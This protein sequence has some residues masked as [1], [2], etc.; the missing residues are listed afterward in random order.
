MAD[1]LSI[2]ASL[3]GVATAAVQSTR[4]LKEAAGRYKTRDATLRRLL[5]E[6]GDVE[7]ILTALEQLLQA[8]TSQPALDVDMSMA[9]L[10]QGPIERCSE[11][12]AKFE[13]AMGHFSNKSKLDFLD[14]TKMEF[15]R[16]DINQFMDTVA[17]YKATISVGLGVLTML[18]HQALEEYD[19]LVKNTICDL[20]LRLQRIDDRLRG[21]APASGPSSSGTGIDLNDERQVTEQCLRI[22]QDAKFYFE[23]VAIRDAPFLQ[24]RPLGGSTNYLQSKFEAQ[25]LT[26][27]ALDDNQTSLVRIITR[28]R[29]RLESVILGGDSS[30]RSQLQEDIQASKQCLEVCKLASTEVSNQ[31]IHIIGEVLADGD[32]DHVV[33]TTLADM[34]NVGKTISK[35]RSAL[36]VGSMS[37]EA[38][39]QLSR[40]R[41]DSR[42]RSAITHDHATQS[43]AVIASETSHPGLTS[44]QPTKTNRQTTNERTPAL[45]NETRKRVS[46]P[47]ASLGKPGGE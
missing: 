29:E 15:M 43:S 45:S 34:F 36:L 40:D 37:D 22:C 18:S 35:N 3:L 4:S 32:S 2:L 47:V 7:N 12:C 8:A 42:F 6:V 14:W 28:L 1:P 44:T 24:D 9:E 26:R 31:K 46:D 21:A 20:K 5:N 19:V 33:V 27:Q 25:L 30:E 23:S 13:R 16:G 38:L 39:M 41:Y 10:L 17:G 11:I